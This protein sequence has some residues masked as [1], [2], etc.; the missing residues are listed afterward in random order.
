MFLLV[1]DPRSE[2]YNMLEILPG[3]RL[4]EKD[5]DLGGSD[6]SAAL[7]VHEPDTVA[8]GRWCLGGEF[9]VD[10]AWGS[11]TRLRELYGDI[12]VSASPFATSIILPGSR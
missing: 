5:S 1:R 9:F 11:P 3:C 6:V 8:G 4:S 10:V 7:E 2:G 12:R